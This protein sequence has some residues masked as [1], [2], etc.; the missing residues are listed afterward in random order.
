MAVFHTRARAVDMLG[1]QQIASVSTAIS[2]VFKNADDAYA[3]QVRADLLSDR[4]CLLIRD[5]GVGMTQNEFERNWLTLA[6]D[7]KAQGAGLAPPKGMKSRPVLGAKGIGRLAIAVVG[8]YSLVLTRSRQPRSPLVY[9]FVNWQVFAE[10]GIDL[11]QVEV[12]LEVVDGGRI[13]T[14]SEVRQLVDATRRNLQE[15][16]PRDRFEALAADLENFDPSSVE[17][18]GDIDGPRL[19]DRKHGTH[20]IISPMDD[21]AVAEAAELSRDSELIIN[22]VGFADTMTPNHPAPTVA[23]S[24]WVHAGADRGAVDVLA[25]GEFLTVEDFWSADHQ[26]TG[27]FDEEGRFL[28]EV[29]VYG[30]KPRPYE[31]AWRE[32]VGATKC[33]P[34]GFAVAIIQPKSSE[35]RMQQADHLR[36]D[37]KLRKMGGIYVY[38]EGI[39]VLPYGRPDVDWLDI[40]ESRTKRLGSAFYSHRRI[41]GS[42]SITNTANGLLQEKAGREGFQQNLAYRQLRALLKSFLRSSAADFFV[43][44]G[45]F[46]DSYMQQKDASQRKARARQ[47][48]QRAVEKTQRQFAQRLATAYVRLTDGAAAQEV[49]KILADFRR[50]VE[51][52]QTGDNPNTL[53][54]EQY[55]A[56]AKLRDLHRSLAV[57]PPIDIG[58]TREIRRDQ[59][60]Y[61]AAMAEFEGTVLDPA[62]LKVETIAAEAGLESVVPDTV[63]VLA[64]IQN[65]GRRAV[66]EA[67]QELQLSVLELQSRANGLIDEA[68]ALVNDGVS[69]LLQEDSLASALKL[70]TSDY[71]VR[72]T[73]LERRAD[74]IFEVAL[75][76]VSGFASVVDRVGWERDG[77]VILTSA[78]VS[79]AVDEEIAELRDDADESMDLVQLGMTL[80]IVDHE[81]QMIIRALRRSLRE[82]HGWAD[83]NPTLGPLVDELHSTFEHLDSYLTLFTPLQRRLNRTRTLISGDDI[84]RFV[85]SLFEVRL[86]DAKI[87]LSATPA[88]LRHNLRGYRSTWYPVFVNLVDNAVYWVGESKPPRRI[89]L[90]VRDGSVIIADS[91]RGVGPEDTERI[92]EPQF[93]LKPGG[94]GLG[95][96]ISREVLAREGYGLDVNPDEDLGG[97]AFVIRRTAFGSAG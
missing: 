96:T 44:G 57:E 2:E 64:Q 15:L 87:E 26:I 43:Q 12:P 22:L 81:F 7:N 51:G 17:L 73:A 10:P 31:L 21:E 9:A 8:P 6:T 30:A 32:A 77:N 50:K 39:R 61:E 66:D 62:R 34:F 65:L 85:V 95:L 75:G 68:A 36:L 76:A 84:Y 46:S 29:R 18:L 5:D 19:T 54:V 1:R 80:A 92:F 74:E 47:Q 14:A 27:E 45:A 37:E 88:F 83:L 16:L 56:V 49:A 42:V 3:T 97:A 24:L 23:P 91:G 35:S 90:D 70:S 78:D 69:I 53:E 93:T 63:R 89:R 41:F 38:R 79:A 4:R 13:P 25:S 82:L 72:R 86:A 58:L 40:E 52:T 59:A 60:S 55:Q 11:D 33:G 67:N 28:G 20:F 94:R 71:L 48:R